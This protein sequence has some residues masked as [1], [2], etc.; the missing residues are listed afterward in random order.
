MSF[1][2]ADLGDA[3]EGFTYGEMLDYFGCRFGSETQKTRNLHRTVMKEILWDIIT[4]HKWNWLR[5]SGTLNLTQGEY[6][7]TLADEVAFIDGDIIVPGLAIIQRKSLTEVRRLIANGTLGS[8]STN[9][10]SVPTMY[11]STGRQTIKV[12]LAPSQDMTGEYDYSKFVDEDMQEMADE[13]FPPLPASDRHLLIA[14]VEYKL[15]LDD[16]R[17]D[18]G[19]KVSSAR[20]EQIMQTLIYREQGSEQRQMIPDQLPPHVR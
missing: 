6:N 2:T 4:R 7:Y 18:V 13:D 17:F 15:R 12:A 3:D 9:P 14:G 11:A 19:T 1:L 20:Y 5:G 10:Q 8:G 16:D